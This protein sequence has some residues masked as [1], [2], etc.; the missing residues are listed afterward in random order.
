M[1]YLKG[2]CC[3]ELLQNPCSKIDQKQIPS[4]HRLHVIENTICRGGNHTEVTETVNIITEIM[5][6]LGNEA[7]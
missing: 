2:F 6:E 3:Q 5:M 7:V 1:V 4:P